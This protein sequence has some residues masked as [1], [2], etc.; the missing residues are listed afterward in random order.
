MSVVKLTVLLASPFDATSMFTFEQS[1]IDVLNVFISP[2]D[3]LNFAVLK[4]LVG[5]LWKIMFV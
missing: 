2:Q 3:C 1:I 5:K 4:V